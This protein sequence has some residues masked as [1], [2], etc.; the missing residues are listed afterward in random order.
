[1]T[2]IGCGRQTLQVNERNECEWCAAEVDGYNDGR[3][4]AAEFMFHVANAAA[5]AALPSDDE[6]RRVFEYVMG[7]GEALYPVSG[8]S[9]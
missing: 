7:G 8:V 2:C 6:V 9:R 3:R 5:R 1:M 4:E